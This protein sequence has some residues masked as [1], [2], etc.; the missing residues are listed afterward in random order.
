LTHNNDPNKIEKDLMGLLPKEDWLVLNHL[1]VTHG[2]QVCKARRPKCNVCTLKLICPL[3]E[4]TN[5]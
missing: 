2:R 4:F 3:G 5:F 1:F